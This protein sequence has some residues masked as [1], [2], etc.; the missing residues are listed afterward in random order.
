MKSKTKTK[1]KRSQTKKAITGEAL[2]NQV[3]KLT[4]LPTKDIKH[5]LK[6]IL[7]Y[8][9]INVY[10]LNLGQ[11]RSAAASYVREIMISL[12]DKYQHKKSDP[13]H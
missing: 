13:V 2:L 11:L 8:K 12:M 6:E 5:E 1:R 4:G 10:Q 9:N 7:K 3:V